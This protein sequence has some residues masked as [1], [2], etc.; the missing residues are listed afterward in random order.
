MKISII[1]SSIR[2]GRNSHRVAL[3]FKEFLTDNTV[4]EAEIIDLKNYSFP[5]FTKR[6]VLQEAPTLQMSEFA[7][8]IKVS[9]GIIIVTPEYNGS[10]PASLKNVIDFLYDEWHRKPV[11]L[12]TVSTGAFG[13]AQALI[14]LQFILWKMHA[15][16]VSAVFQV[17]AVTESF[18]E[19]GKAI[20]KEE[21]KK[22]ANMMIT[23]LLWCIEAN[24]RMSEPLVLANTK[25]N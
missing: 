12:A 24:N 18:N 16:T 3:Y 19:S 23:E 25:L 5:I 4:A 13:G 17:A 8:K 10:I 6:F 22:Q 9:D 11:A 15:W 20:D 7:E 2:D 14:S 1:S 21:S